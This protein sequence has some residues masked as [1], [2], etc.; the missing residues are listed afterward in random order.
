MAE[1]EDIVD[2]DL[3]SSSGE[4][5]D[6]VDKLLTEI[7]ITK[8]EDALKDELDYQFEKFEDMLEKVETGCRNL[9]SFNGRVDSCLDKTKYTLG[10]WIFPHLPIDNPLRND[11]VC[12][13]EPSGVV[14]KPRSFSLVATK[15]VTSRFVDGKPRMSSKFPQSTFDSTGEVIPVKK[16]LPTAHRLPP[17]GA[18]VIKPPLHI[19]MKVYCMAS[20][21]KGMWY[22][23][24]ILEILEGNGKGQVQY[25]VKIEKKNKMYKTMSGKNLAYMLRPNVILP[26]GTRVIAEYKEEPTLLSPTSNKRRGVGALYVG[27]IAEPPKSMNNYMYLIFFDDGYAQYSQMEEVF[28]VCESSKNVWEDIHPDTSHF[29]KEYLTQYPERPMVKLQRGQSVR[30]EWNGSWWTARVVT[31]HGSLVKMFFEADKRT[32]WIY[33]GST[34]LG[35]LFDR[36]IKMQKLPSM[37]RVRR[38]GLAS[39]INSQRLPYV[40]Y[41]YSRDEKPDQ[42]AESEDKTVAIQESASRNV[43]RK[44]LS[45]PAKDPDHAGRIIESAMA[46]VRIGGSVEKVFVNMPILPQ[47]KSHRKCEPSCL[48]NSPDDIDAY[49]GTNPLEI[50]TYCGWRREIVKDRPGR[51]K[52]VFYVAPCGRRLRSIEETN[53]YLTFTKSKLTIDLFCF[54]SFVQTFQ[55]YIPGTILMQIR[56]ISYGKESVP[57]SCVSTINREKPDYV[58]YSNKRI[59]GRGVEI[60]LDEDFLACCDCTDNCQDKSKCGCQLLTV[61]A[62]KLAVSNETDPSAGYVNKRLEE[63]LFTGLYEC[64]Q[65]CKCD[66][67]C[68][69]RVVQNGLRNRLQLFKTK[70]KGWG[71]RT[72]DDLPKGSFICIYAGQLLTEQEANQDGTQY[73]DEYMAEL[74]YIEVV[75]NQHKD[76]YESDLPD[77]ED[78]GLGSG[79]NSLN[80]DVLHEDSSD[81][82][83][84]LHPTKAEKME[85]GRSES[86]VDQKNSSETNDGPNDDDEKLNLK[87]EARKDSTE[88]IDIHDYGENLAAKDEELPDLDNSNNVLMKSRILLR[89]LSPE[90]E[91]K[92]KSH[93]S[94]RRPRLEAHY[95]DKGESDSEEGKSSSKTTTNQSDS[96]TKDSSE[97]DEAESQDDNSTDN[98]RRIISPTVKHSLSRSKNSVTSSQ[99]NIQQD[100][101]DDESSVRLYFG[102]Q[103]C[104]VM[105]AKSSGNIGRY[106]NHSCGPNVFVQNVFVDTHDLR[107]PWVAFFAGQMIKAGEELTWDYNYEVGSVKGRE[108]YCHCGS[109]NCRGRLL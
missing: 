76:G 68:M 2:S 102:E 5:V 40:E 89:P 106:L 96:D 63:Q 104:Y 95:S 53:R 45:K 64:N 85:L 15:K 56:D 93:K 12:I 78:E 28:L 54:D 24:S 103:Y 18:T 59:P 55:N 57:V 81:S 36:L 30:T 35:P 62:T 109:N 97:K 80:S 74:D 29:V 26:V 48:E 22:S 90:T 43:A 91:E 19:G 1:V 38:Q 77:S 61:E 46:G 31:V 47:Y 11:D 98:I 87:D 32:E 82:D 9:N 100:A 16:V 23:G 83:F 72:L 65:R 39:G 3:S 52:I 84:V 34:R 42:E 27:I 66:Y 51:K 50:P 17:I 101:Q 60:N 67:R 8:F 20:T 79:H 92:L 70:A 108:I 49:K 4:D 107:F 14:P 44:S 10:K 69:N 37:G 21:F 86:Q 71:L 6:N 94:A 7:F 73:G 58:E 75:E 33:R 13:L 99:P 25:K 88:S 105:D 41:T